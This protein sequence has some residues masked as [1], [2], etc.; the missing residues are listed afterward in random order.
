MK[1]CNFARWCRL[2]TSLIDR[3]MKG[4][5]MK[6][7]AVLLAVWYCMSIVGFDVHT[8]KGSGRAFVTTFAEGMTCADI[9]PEQHCTHDRHHEASCC[10]HESDCCAHHGQEP[11]ASVDS[12]TCCTDS[13]QVIVL[14]GCRAED[15]GHDSVDCGCGYCPYIH[16]C[17]SDWQASLKYRPSSHY[18]PDSGD[19]VP[20]DRCVTF[21]VW[22]I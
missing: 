6:I 15:D 16:A 2:W 5:W 1:I 8:C 11:E 14:T 18:K 7:C 21:G 3:Q 9:H 12:Q 20:C 17:A 13:Y 22:R 10:H 19:I 4:F